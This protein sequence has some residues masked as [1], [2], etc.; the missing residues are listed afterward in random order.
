MKQEGIISTSWGMVKVE[1]DDEGISYLSLPYVSIQNYDENPI[2]VLKEMKIALEDY[3]QGKLIEFP[4]ETNI[5]ALTPFQQQVLQAIKNIPYGEVR[6]YKWVAEQAG[7]PKGYRAVGGALG[8]NPIPIIIPCHRVIAANGTLGGFT[9][10]LEIKRRLL[11]LEKSWG[12][13]GRRES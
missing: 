4:F 12:H 13:R 2:G 5:T 7:C 8:S 6:S 3:F 1:W 11:D 9:G 10:G